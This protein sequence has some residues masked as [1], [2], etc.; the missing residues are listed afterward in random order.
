[1]KGAPA[2]G[3][4]ERMERRL[5]VRVADPHGVLK[6][7]LHL[8][9]PDPSL[10]RLLRGRLGMRLPLRVR[11]GWG[12][13]LRRR[14]LLEAVRSEGAEVGVDVGREAG[15]GLLRQ[16][17]RL[18]VGLGLRL[19]LSLLHEKELALELLVLGRRG[20]GGHR[21]GGGGGLGGVRGVLHGDGGRT[22]VAPGVRFGGNGVSLCS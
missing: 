13:E 18:R 7:H 8:G 5:D 21:R 6:R 22:G 20:Y 2:N 11:L 17:L 9:A 15:H 16:L 4:L 14:R 10:R 3:V 19:S 1:M 12:L